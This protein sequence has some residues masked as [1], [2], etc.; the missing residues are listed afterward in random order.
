MAGVSSVGGI[1]ESIMFFMLVVGVGFMEVL[2]GQRC[3]V[4]RFYSNTQQGVSFMPIISLLSSLPLRVYFVLLCW[5]NCYYFHLS[6]L[7]FYFIIHYFI[8]SL[9]SYFIIYYTVIIHSLHY[10]VS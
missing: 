1:L 6:F 2:Q 10:T 9:F 8:I 7:Y 5:N 3:S 4:W